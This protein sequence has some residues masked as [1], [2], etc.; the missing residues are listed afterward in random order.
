MFID[1]MKENVKVV[2]VREEYV[3]EKSWKKPKEED[4]WHAYFTEFIVIPLCYYCVC[5]LYNVWARV[6]VNTNVYVT[7]LDSLEQYHVFI[8]AF[9]YLFY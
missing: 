5:Q 7:L 8:C 4:F 3:E 2:G 6:Y 1:V 9:L